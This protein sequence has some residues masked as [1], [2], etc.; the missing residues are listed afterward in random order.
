MLF[1]IVSERFFRAF[2]PFGYVFDRPVMVKAIRKALLTAEAFLRSAVSRNLP[3]WA[4]IPAGNF[5]PSA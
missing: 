4:K 5:T 2:T 1:P 3:Y